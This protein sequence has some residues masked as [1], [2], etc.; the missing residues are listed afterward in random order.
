MGRK[1]VEDE[2]RVQILEGL[3]RCLLKKPYL[4]TSIKDIAQESG[5]NH[6]VLHYYFKNK[7]EILSTFIEHVI[8]EYRADFDG[9]LVAQGGDRLPPKQLME[10]IFG[11][12]NDRITLNR[13]LSKIFIEIWEISA[14]NRKVRSRLRRVYEEWGR[15]LE[16]VIAGAEP[17]RDKARQMGMAIISFHEGMAL[18]SIILKRKDFPGD[19]ILKGFQERV[20]NMF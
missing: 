10:R 15:I 18:F 12:M 6:G 13:D 2:R 16:G 1:K 8:R 17:D 11:Y 9:W 20:L 5:V 4:E 14:Y 7:E 19:E 3:Y